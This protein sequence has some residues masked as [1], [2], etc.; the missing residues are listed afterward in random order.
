AGCRGLFT[1]LG[2]RLGLLATNGDTDTAQAAGTAPREQPA[3][4]LF[5]VVVLVVLIGGGVYRQVVPGDGGQV[6]VRRYV[7]GGDVEVIARFE[8]HTV[9]TDRAGGGVG[10]A[11]A[12]AGDRGRAGQKTTAGMFGGSGPVVVVFTVF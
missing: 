12:V 1:Q 4:R 11:L 2:G 6:V 5:L 3:G 9:A 8:C 7:A 10:V